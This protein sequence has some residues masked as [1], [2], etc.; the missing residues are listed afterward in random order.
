MNKEHTTPFEEVIDEIMLEESEPSHEVLMRWIARYPD[1]REA[2]TRFFATWA[3]QEASPKEKPVDEALAGQRM[4]SEAMNL[5]YKQKAAR[6][7]AVSAEK[8]PRLC[9][10]IKAQAMTEEEFEA[11]CSL[12]HLIIAKLD[13][14]LIRPASIPRRCLERMAAA[15]GKVI[16]EVLAIVGGNPIPLH[17]YKAKERPTVKT[18]DFIDAV[19]S[20]TLSNEAKA[21]WIEAVAAEDAK[22]G[23]S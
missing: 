10:A 17:S 1:H 18:E 11:R 5:L 4:V 13:R 7:A 12:D 6:A 16:D 19:R 21:E 9:D 23:A 20:S 22:K 8:A 14:R 2:L 15:L 3:V